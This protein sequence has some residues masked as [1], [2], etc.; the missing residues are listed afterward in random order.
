M[1]L[2]HHIQCERDILKRIYKNT[3]LENLASNLK[4]FPDC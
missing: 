3:S 2:I 4:E 1:E